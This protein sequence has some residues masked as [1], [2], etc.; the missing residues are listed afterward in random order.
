[1]ECKKEFSISRALEK[2]SF[3]LLGIS[4]TC[5]KSVLKLARYPKRKYDFF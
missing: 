3:Y 5:P 2:R 1:V 4:R